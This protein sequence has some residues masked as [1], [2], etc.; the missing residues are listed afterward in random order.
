MAYF[1]LHSQIYT[2]QPQEAVTVDW[3]QP[4]SVGLVHATVGDARINLAG[5]QFINTMNTPRWSG[6]N[7]GNL[8]GIVFQ[9]TGIVGDL[10]QP[11]LG[12]ETTGLIMH[13]PDLTSARLIGG[14]FTNADSSNSRFEIFPTGFSASFR[15]SVSADAT[16]VGIIT[17]QVGTTYTQMGRWFADSVELWMDGRLIST[18]SGTNGQIR[19]RVSL[20]ADT[21]FGG[22]SYSGA[23]HCSLWWN[24]TLTP[25]EIIS[26]SA[27]PWQLF[28]R[29][30][31]VWLDVAAAIFTSSRAGINRGL[32][33]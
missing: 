24:R 25:D 14:A 3:S 28:Q 2:H 21:S 23:I 18:A 4:L 12:R 33:R 32:F 15:S 11:W 10:T 19:N 1:R 7:L 8:P 29:P 13:T 5:P 17:P 31:N 9:N 30:G 16:S 22:N 27:N 26:I 20:G 6:G